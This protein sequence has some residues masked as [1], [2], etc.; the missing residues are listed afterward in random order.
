MAAAS[1][2]L[3]A[4]PAL[5]QAAPDPTNVGSVQANVAVAS[6][7]TLSGLPVGFTLSGIPTATVATAAPVTMTVWTNNTQGYTVTVQAATATLSG[8]LPG[9]TNTIPVGALQVRETG[10]G[11]YQNVTN[12]P[13][14]VLVYGKNAPSL[15]TGDLLSNDYSM[16][17]PFVVPDTYTATLNYV[18][19]T[20]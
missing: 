11:T 7:I 9:N 6:A 18:A 19:A 4:F 12:A 14:G 5:A 13:G 10:T 15:E 16:T 3:F 20:L 17:I 1:V 2:A 8:A